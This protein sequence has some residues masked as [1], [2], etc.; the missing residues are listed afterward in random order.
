M[1]LRR[2]PRRRVTRR[3]YRL[4]RRTAAG[5]AGAR[6]RRRSSVYPSSRSAGRR[7][8]PL[9]GKRLTPIRRA[10]WQGLNRL[11]RAA[12]NRHLRILVSR[13]KARARKRHVPIHRDHRNRP[14]TDGPVRRQR[15]RDRPEADGHEAD[16]GTAIEAL[17]P[18]RRA[19][20]HSRRPTP[21][22]A[23]IEVPRSALEGHVSPR[24]T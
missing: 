21:A 13:R 18:P 16:I 8:I 22:E 1:A 17:S 24:V 20:A 23:V 15:P 5:V 10:R 3:L 2:R 12:R 19:A 14:M 6:I 9:C 7:A 4:T 11:H